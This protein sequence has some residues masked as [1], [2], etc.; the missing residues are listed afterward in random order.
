[1]PLPSRIAALVCIALLPLLSGCHES[2]PNYEARIAALEACCAAQ[3]AEIATQ[4]AA[5][6]AL[7]A[8]TV[9]FSD[10]TGTID[11]AQVPDDI[12]IDFAATAGDA[13]TL[14]GYHAN[15]IAES[16]SFTPTIGGFT[17]GWAVEGPFSYL[18]TGN[19]VR[20]TGSIRCNGFFHFFPDPLTLGSLPYR[21]TAFAGSNDAIGVASPN[22]FDGS[23]L[24]PTICTLAAL[25]GTSEVDL[26]LDPGAGG[27]VYD[28]GTIS[29]DFSYDVDP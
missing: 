10:L 25:V 4:A 20:V 8:K 23:F 15:E 24:G 7:Q 6:A 29:V 11:D 16:G 17:P 22:L 1:M 26:S 3:A 12:T 19:R 21:L 2:S 28:N 13:D 9:A 14:D 5:I 27:P 18:R